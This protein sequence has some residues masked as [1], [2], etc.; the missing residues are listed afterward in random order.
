MADTTTPQSRT[1]FM[2][3]IVGPFLIIAAV[4]VALRA[5]S[6]DALFPAFFQDTPLVLITGV[7]TLMVG[8]I[9]I[10]A[11]HHWTTLASSVIS[12]LGIMTTLRGLVL[13]LAPGIAASLAHGVIASPIV[14]LALAVL[15]A[16]VGAW[17]TFVGFAIPAAGK[18]S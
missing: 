4:T 5:D 7:F 13:M 2:A 3:R 9:M 17:L 16:L 15:I 14:P 12:L 18:A 8:L 10:S 11:H 6:V 1:R